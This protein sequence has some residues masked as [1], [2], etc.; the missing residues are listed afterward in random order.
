MSD[1]TNATTKETRLLEALSA[2]V[3]NEA[4]ELEVRRLLAESEKSE[5]LRARWQRYQLART[6]MKGEAMADCRDL[7]L[8]DGVRAAVADIDMDAVEKVPTKASKSSAKKGWLASA[9][10]LAIAASV[11]G[12]VL[13]GAQQVSLLAG[14]NNGADTLADITP[15]APAPA[16]PTFNPG[17]QPVSLGEPVRQQSTANNTGYAAAITEEQLRLQEMLLRQ[18]FNQLMLEHAEQAAQNSGAGLMPYA[19]AP[20]MEQ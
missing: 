17:L 11:A 9:G 7:N 2:L 13:L 8:L 12:T 3:D 15:S 19:R 6:A 1:T 16:M 18:Y 14:G 5:M 10:R 4:T 20:Q